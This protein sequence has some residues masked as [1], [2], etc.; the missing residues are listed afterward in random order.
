MLPH[1]VDVPLRALEHPRHELAGYLVRV[2]ARARVR[3]RV[4]LGLGAL[5]RLLSQAGGPHDG[6]TPPAMLLSFLTVTMFACN[7]GAHLASRLAGLAE[8][9]AWSP[10]AFVAPSDRVDWLL[11]G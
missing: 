4:R 5:M 10:T 1:C 9:P 8:A 6:H 2:R 7:G 3:L 11:I